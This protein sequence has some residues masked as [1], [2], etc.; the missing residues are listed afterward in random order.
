M[1]IIPVSQLMCQDARVIVAPNMMEV[2]AVAKE[3]GKEKTK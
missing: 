3:G 2:E 1:T